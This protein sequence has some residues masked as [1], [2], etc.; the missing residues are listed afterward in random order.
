LARG[1]APWLVR[2]LVWQLV[3]ENSQV[4]SASVERESKS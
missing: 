1:A 4:S 3:R 2:R